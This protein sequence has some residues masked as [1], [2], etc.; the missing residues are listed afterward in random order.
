MRSFA[1][2]LMLLLVVLSHTCRGF[3]SKPYHLF[4]FTFL[5][6][7]P[8]SSS[9]SSSSS[10]DE[11]SVPRSRFWR[12]S[13]PIENSESASVENVVKSLDLSD[14]DSGFL[15]FNSFVIP[16]QQG[17]PQLQHITSTPLGN[18]SVTALGLHPRASQV[19]VSPAEEE[20]PIDWKRKEALDTVLPLI[21][22][23][24]AEELLSAE[25][26]GTSP[27]RIYRSFVAP[28]PGAN[29]L[30]ETIERAANRTANQ[31][32]LGVR[33]VLADRAA[34]L[35]NTD[36]SAFNLTHTLNPIAV[37]VDNVRSAL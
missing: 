37:V 8:Q 6:R 32:D 19:E 1:N 34:Y 14:V 12:R 15:F 16:V 10:I 11:T 7:Q 13:Y 29:R 33:Q 20:R 31:I 18:T 28:R 35:R 9:S 17:Q 24:T 5:Q 23:F 26:A 22:N 3:T 27:V 25:F 36:R 21:A 2:E 4:R 30:L